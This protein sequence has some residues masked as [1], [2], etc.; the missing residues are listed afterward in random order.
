MAS[1]FD[2]GG[3][4]RAAVQPKRAGGVDFVFCQGPGEYG[5]THREDVGRADKDLL[6]VGSADAETAGK[7]AVPC[8][9]PD[10]QALGSR[11]KLSTHS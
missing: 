2:S 1:H 8:P 7:D 3:C 5:G 4:G 10:T 6:G 11:S 9:P